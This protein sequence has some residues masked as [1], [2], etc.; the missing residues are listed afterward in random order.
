M[1]GAGSIP[2]LW[3]LEE[4]TLQRPAPVLS[5]ERTVCSGSG[6]HD[7]DTSSDREGSGAHGEAARESPE[8][9]ATRE[10]IE[11]A[12]CLPPGTWVSGFLL[13]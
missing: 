5:W 10:R 1:W 11:G 8:G 2:Q 7:L 9:W 3:G 6:G 4:V 13:R 12:H